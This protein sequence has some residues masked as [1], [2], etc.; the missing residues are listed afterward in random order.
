M[1]QGDTTT[2]T[3]ETAGMTEDYQKLVNN[4]ISEKVANELE[5]IY[6]SGDLF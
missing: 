2:K 6:K 3:M 5:K 4:G 1:K